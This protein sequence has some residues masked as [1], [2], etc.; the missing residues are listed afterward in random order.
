M[1]LPFS[2]PTSDWKAVDI[3]MSSMKPGRLWGQIDEAWKG[4]KS[5]EIVLNLLPK[6]LIRVP[7][8]SF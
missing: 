4:D 1:C 8:D 3:H 6:I 7:S 2:P 5:E